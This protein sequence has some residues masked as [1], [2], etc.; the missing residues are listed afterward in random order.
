MIKIFIPEAK[1]KSVKNNLAR[2]F[3]KNEAGKIY[4][5]YLRLK[6]Y[7]LLYRP[8]VFNNLYAIKKLSFLKTYYNQEAIF[9]KSGNC[10]FIYYNDYK[11]E[12]LKNRI[13]KIVTR[14]DLKV[15]I[16]EFLKKYNGVTVYIKKEKFII[17]AFYND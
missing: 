16:K 15:T 12:I 8:G 13:E 9:F 1:R 11:I 2:G 14:Q 4:Y 6:N 5:D 17:E 3:W 7:P 10:G